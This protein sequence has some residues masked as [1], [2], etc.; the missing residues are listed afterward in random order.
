MEQRLHK[1]EFVECAVRLVQQGRV[2]A[3]ARA[4][5]M[6]PEGLG[7]ECPGVV[8]NSGQMVGLEF[9]KPGHPRSTSYNVSARVVHA[10]LKSVGLMLASD[11]L[12][13]MGFPEHCS[14]V[15]NT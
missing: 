2:V 9:I 6:S 12:L 13:H 10:G 14:K 8:L 3:I 7:I 1:R 15:E 4:I 5:D 11:S